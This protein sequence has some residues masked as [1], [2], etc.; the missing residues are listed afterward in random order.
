MS[1]YQAIEF[2]QTGQRDD[3]RTRRR[4]FRRGCCLWLA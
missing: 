1:I 3:A 2:A 4:L